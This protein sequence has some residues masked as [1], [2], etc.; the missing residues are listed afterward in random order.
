M[1]QQRITVS[2]YYIKTNLNTASQDTFSLKQH[3]LCSGRSPQL[4]TWKK[5]LMEA[6]DSRLSQSAPKMLL[7]LK[8]Q[9][10]EA[11]LSSWNGEKPIYLFTT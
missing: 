10:T 7:T 6:A 1:N 9:C 3:T 2:V 11:V 5:A 8:E 4:S